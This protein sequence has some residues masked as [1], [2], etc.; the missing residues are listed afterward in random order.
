MVAGLRRTIAVLMATTMPA[1]LGGCTSGQSED[2]QSAAEA[3]FVTSEPTPTI[4]LTPAVVDVPLVAEVPTS[5]EE[6]IWW[7]VRAANAFSIVESE[8][9][10]NHPDDTSMLNSIAK[11]EPVTIVDYYARELVKSGLV[12][13]GA[14]EQWVLEEK[15]VVLP[16][17]ENPESSFGRVEVWKCSGTG[18]ISLTDADGNSVPHR[19]I[20]PAPRWMLAEYEVEESAWFITA[21]SIDPVADYEC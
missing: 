16:D 13:S 12:R 20:A 1:L 8:V 7:A 4:G 14:A 18:G 17:P 5:E 10:N 9:M 19:Y 15:S 3:S 6:A 21:I 11:G 2:G